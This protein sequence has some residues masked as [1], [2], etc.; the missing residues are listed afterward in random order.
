MLED[1]IVGKPKGVGD[2]VPKYRRCAG[3]WRAS[4]RHCFRSHEVSTQVLST[5]RCPLRPIEELN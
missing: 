4:C 2:L 3:L 5:G 1:I